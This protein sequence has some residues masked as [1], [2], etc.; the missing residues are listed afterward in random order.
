MTPWTVAHQASLSV[1]VLQARILEWV[2]MPSSR[3]SFQPKNRT[4]DWTQVSTLQA[5]SLPTEPPGTYTLGQVNYFPWLRLHK[6]DHGLVNFC[7][8]HW[9]MSNSFVTLGTMPAR[10]LC[11]WDFPGKN[12][13]V[14]CHFLLQG[15]F[16]TRDW[17]WVSCIAGGILHWRQIL[18]KLS[19]QGSLDR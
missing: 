17:T 16:L 5:D 2:A 13:G 4:K 1:G 11:P 15:V 3:G 14:G 7:C 9:V 8:N 6:A 12:T 19:H 18:Y 10:L